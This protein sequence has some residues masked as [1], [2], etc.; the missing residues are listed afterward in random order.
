M[1]L[2]STFENETDLSQIEAEIGKNI[3]HLNQE[4]QNF[5]NQKVPRSMILH[6]KA[7][8]EFHELSVFL[9]PRSVTNSKKLK[10]EE[11]IRVATLINICSKLNFTKLFLLISK[12]DNLVKCY[13][14]GSRNSQLLTVVVSKIGHLD[15]VSGFI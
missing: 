12:L 13:R 15:I 5:E 7:Q 9:E 2:C 14:S 3:E 4:F 8:A 10:N 6:L 11:S 1:A